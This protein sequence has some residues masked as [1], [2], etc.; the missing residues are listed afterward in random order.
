MGGTS[1]AN[2]IA[3]YLATI[4]AAAIYSYAGR[5]LSPRE[6]PLP[7]H[8]GGFGGAA[9]L[10]C[11]LEDNNI[12]HLVDATHPFAK[13]ISENAAIAC[14]NLVTVLI[15]FERKSWDEQEGD[16]WILSANIDAAV[17][18]LGSQKFK[19]VFL[20]TGMQSLN[21]FAALSETSLVARVVEQPP[22]DSFGLANAAFEIARGPFIV[23]DEI[24]L[25]EKHRIDLIVSKNSGGKGAYAKINAAR[26]LGIPILMIERPVIN[27][28]VDF[29]YVSD[30][31]NHLECL[32][33]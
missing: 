25:F 3:K 13:Q 31:L 22:A 21:K 10:T 29:Q 15:R 33:V 6:I 28:P 8:V 5:T 7:V 32:G 1:E 4:G 20:A 9:G 11:F 14:K 23:D 2:Q 17:Q 18:W 26:T 12:T 24:A 19:Q 27:A 16:D 30:L